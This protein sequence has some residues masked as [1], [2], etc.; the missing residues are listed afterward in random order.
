[1]RPTDGQSYLY[2]ARCLDEIDCIL[3]MLV[4]ASA[5]DQNIR[6]EDNVRRPESDAFGEQTI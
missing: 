4:N 2:Y 6:I 1:V 3:I 5:D